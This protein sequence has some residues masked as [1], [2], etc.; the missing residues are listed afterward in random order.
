MED[1]LE[2]VAVLK[3]KNG[4]ARAGGISNLLN[5]KASSVTSAL[6]TLAKSGFVLH[7]R[8]GYVELTKKGKELS[9][10]IQKQHDILTKF[11]TDVLSV[12][13]TIAIED[14]CKME[15]TLSPQTF[16]KLT[17]FI[18][19]VAI[20]PDGQRPEWLKSLDYYLKTGKR[21]RCKIKKIKQGL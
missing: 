8:Y 1:Y 3:K 12:D 20:R 17:E 11:L 13:S 6:N 7:E 14:A 16:Q 9:H 2:A 21:L 4:V 10:H 15:H 18:K 19:F 5:V